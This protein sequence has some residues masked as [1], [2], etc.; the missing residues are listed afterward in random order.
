MLA[1]KITLS[2]IPLL[3]VILLLLYS[4]ATWARQIAVPAILILIL[5]D[6][7]DGYLARKRG[8]E[9]ILGSVLDIASDRAVEYVLWVTF[10]QLGLIPL[11]IP[12]VILVRGTFVD[13]IR[14]V[15]PARGLKPFELLQSPLGRFLVS[16]PWLRT[17]YAVIKVM[18]FALLA[19][20][21]ALQNIGNS[22]GETLYLPAQIAAWVAV[23]FCLARGLPVLLE[24]PRALSE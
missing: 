15:A 3:F 5:M 19:V 8:E 16:S 2:R 6:T 4:P 14:S 22:W 17:P 20:V 10:A 24:A 9:S 12:V 7:L 13:A 1:N 11:V 21:H 18:A 23:A